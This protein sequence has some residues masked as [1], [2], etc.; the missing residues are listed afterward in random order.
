M[1][2]L[3]AYLAWRKTT[4]VIGDV[5]VWKAACEWQKNRDQV[6]VDRLCQEI[7]RLLAIQGGR[8]QE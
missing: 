8:N 6:E 1:T 2:D 4:S 7:A 3:Q 5:A